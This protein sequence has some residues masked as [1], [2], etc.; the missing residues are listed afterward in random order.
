MSIIYIPDIFAQYS[1]GDLISQVPWEEQTTARRE[2]FMTDPAGV[3]YTYGGNRGQRTYVSVEMHPAVREV[4]DVLNNPVEGARNRRDYNACFLNL[5][6]DEHNM[7]GWHADN[8]DGMDGDHPIASVSFGQPRE[9]WWRPNG[10][11]GVV[12][13][14]Q[15][16]LL[17]HGSVFV[18]PGGFQATHQHR[19]PRGDRQMTPRVSM[20]FRRFI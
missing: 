16:Q 1:V 18:M 14:D 4:M 13:V 17:G 20:T 2:C 9:I 15:R 8:F 19:I 10:Q 12:P 11:T 3:T 7:L 6:T 5:Y